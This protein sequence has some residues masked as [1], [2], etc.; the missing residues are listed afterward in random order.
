MRRR[1]RPDRGLRDRGGISRSIDQ[2]SIP[3]RIAAGKLNGVV[4]PIHLSPDW[5][6][7]SL[8][9]LL[10]RIADEVGA[11]VERLER[12]QREALRAEQLAALGQLA[13]GLATSS[14]IPSPG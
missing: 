3:I 2:L 11:V 12:T 1:G 7:E 4:G 9:L 14:A 13:A 5:D 10:R 8:D 6:V